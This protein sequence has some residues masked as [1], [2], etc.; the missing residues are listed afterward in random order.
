MLLEKHDFTVLACIGSINDLE[1]E[2]DSDTPD[3]VLLDFNIPG[4][5]CEDFI[6]LI[7]QNSLDTRILMLTGESSAGSF[8]AMQKLDIDGIALKD[9]NTAELL[10]AIRSLSDGS[11][12]YDKRVSRRLEEQQVYPTPSEAKIL[13]LLVKGLSTADIAEN[14]NLK[15]KTVENHRYNLMQKFEA[16]SSAQLIYLA[17]KQGFVVDS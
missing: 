9:S 14:L 6:R 17:G 13:A 10:H 7:K 16:K 2:L 15:H 1:R 12:F 5:H 8:K 4:F 11:K 3:M